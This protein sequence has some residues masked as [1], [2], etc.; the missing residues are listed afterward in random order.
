MNGV[1]SNV[2]QTSSVVDLR[3]I[4]AFSV[5]AVAGTG[6]CS[7]TFQVQVSNDPVIGPFQ[8]FTFT[9]WVNLGTA[10]TFSQ[11]SVSSNQLVPYQNSSFV[12]MRV[13]FTD[14]SSGTNTALIS[15]ELMALGY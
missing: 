9:N 10:L 5:Q 1:A 13:V 15:V 12:A 7:G 14:S 6:S 8:N 11:S 3:Q 4:F 2:N